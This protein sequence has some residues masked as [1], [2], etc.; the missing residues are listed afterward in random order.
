MLGVLVALALAQDGAP[1]PA[2]VHLRHVRG[3]GAASCPDQAWLEGNVAARLG[4]SPFVPRAPLLVTTRLDCDAHGC[5]ATLEVRH[6]DVPGD[7]PR[8]RTLAA[9][10]CREAAES[11]ALSLALVIDPQH[12]ARPR[13][14][15]VGPTPPAPVSAP[16]PPAPAPL[17]P[18]PTPLPPP[19]RPPASAPTPPVPVFFALEAGALGSLGL[20]PGPS[21]GAR[22]AVG[23]RRGWFGLSLEG[24]ADLPR[25]L[26]VDGGSVDSAVLLGT[27]LPCFRHGG[28][29]VC[30]TASLGAL[31]VTGQLGQ[32]NRASSLLALV[33]A[34]ASW[35]YRFLP[36]LG[37]IVHAGVAGVVTRVTVL[38][39]QQPAW[40]TSYLTPDVGAGVLLLL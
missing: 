35:E 33:G 16:P 11:L 4:A 6:L 28:F 36:W 20:S 17:P 5:R 29:G 14:D 23:F 8:R 37:V 27:L 40:V 3:E 7:R 12:L 39:N 21:A 9:A 19:P 38:A 32:G 15:D 26:A 34:R 30:L 1:P 24:R 22:L 10:D 18:A 2:R 13:P 31:Q 25:A